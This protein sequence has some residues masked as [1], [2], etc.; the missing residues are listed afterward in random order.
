MTDSHYHIEVF[1][2]DTEYD[3]YVTHTEIDSLD[4]L[5]EA[6]TAFEGEGKLDWP[7]QIRIN[8]MEGEADPESILGSQHVSKG[9]R[10]E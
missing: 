10:R 9:G 6:V 4:E 2:T 7:Y 1:R 5:E 3:S 8:K